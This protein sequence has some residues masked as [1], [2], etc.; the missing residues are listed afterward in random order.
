MT[1]DTNEERQIVKPRVNDI[2]LGRGGSSIHNDANVRYR[3]MVRSHKKAYQTYT[4]HQK[5]TLAESLVE[6]WRK[7]NDPPGRF[8][9]LDA[10][11]STWYCISEKSARRK[12]SQLLR[13]G[14]PKI[15]RQLKEE[16]L[17]AAAA[18]PMTPKPAP[19]RTPMGSVVRT[20][21]PAFN[22]VPAAP[23]RKNL[24]R[25]PIQRVSLSKQ[26]KAKLNNNNK[27]NTKAKTTLNLSSPSPVP[28]APSPALGPR[29]PS[30][31]YV[32]PTTRPPLMPH[33]PRMAT[34]S[35]QMFT[36]PPPH[37]HNREN[38]APQQHHK[39]QQPWSSPRPYYNPAPYHSYY[40]PP[41]A[42]PVPVATPT[43]VKPQHRRGALAPV[44]L[45]PKPVLVE[46][47]SSLDNIPMTKPPIAE[48]KPSAP[49][50]ES[51][52]D[53]VELCAD[54]NINSW[55]EDEEVPAGDVVSL[56]S[57]EP[58]AVLNDID[59]EALHIPLLSPPQLERESSSILD[60]PT[61]PP[62]PPR[63]E[64]RKDSHPSYLDTL[65]TFSFDSFDRMDSLVH[66]E[67]LGDS[68][69]DIL[70]ELDKEMEAD[71][72]LRPCHSL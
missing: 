15:R 5:T 31:P 65:Q 16:S 29:T 10:K 14:A 35:P 24:P 56:G 48:R 63:L 67:N 27:S 36:P 9:E 41:A 34:P 25:G 51:V 13:E 71:L 64:F 44:P 68:T 72:L 26:A 20:P 49:S 54:V 4:R 66:S 7:E 50:P 53:F 2:L 28:V 37:N 23:P 62:S 18:A 3:T 55:D 38:W 11:T 8:L 43:P 30:R 47:S 6:N 58:T 39:W 22:A 52:L 61:C 42:A 57:V 46:R 59:D 45:Q 40:A 12:T 21:S 70:N 32:A 17:A 19:R 1:K 33:A 60:M 69:I